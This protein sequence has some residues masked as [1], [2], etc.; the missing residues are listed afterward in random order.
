ME[1][2]CYVGKEPHKP[3][4]NKRVILYLKLYQICMTCFDFIE[5]IM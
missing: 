1:A 4:V 5:N 2:A 3:Q